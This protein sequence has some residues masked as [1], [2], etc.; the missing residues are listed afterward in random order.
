MQHRSYKLARAIFLAQP[1]RYRKRPWRFNIYLTAC[2][3][4]DGGWTYWVVGETPTR[5]VD[6]AMRFFLAKVLRI[7]ERGQADGIRLIAIWSALADHIALKRLVA[8]R[9]ECIYHSGSEA[10]LESP[11]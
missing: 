9:Q 5:S 11:D 3:H 6:E 8:L 4:D 2:K 7:Q 1:S 10:D